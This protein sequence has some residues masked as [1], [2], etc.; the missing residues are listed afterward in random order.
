MT[1][2]LMSLYYNCISSVYWQELQFG[3][4]KKE[5]HNKVTDSHEP[6]WM[7]EELGVSKRKD[8]VSPEKPGVG[9]NHTWPWLDVQE[10]NPEQWGTPAALDYAQKHNGMKIKTGSSVETDGFQLRNLWWRNM[11]IDGKNTINNLLKNK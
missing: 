2:V 8:G 6:I 7:V 10:A 11:K 4:A 9:T 1:L 3:W 5:P